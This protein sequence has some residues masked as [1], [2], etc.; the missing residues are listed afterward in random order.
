VEGLKAR[1]NFF[2]RWH[3]QLGLLAVP[4]L[5][6]HACRY[7]YAH[8]TVLWWSYLATVSAGFCSPSLTGIRDRSYVFGWIIVHTAL[9][10]FVTGLAAYHAYVAFSY[11]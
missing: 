2:L 8:Q 10:L 5:W 9:S 11:A 1:N 4:L 3:V 7:G 6:L